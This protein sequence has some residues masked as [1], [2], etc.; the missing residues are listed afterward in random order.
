MVSPQPLA[1]SSPEYAIR[2]AG[3]SVGHRRSSSDF[4]I[5]NIVGQFDIGSMTAILG[6]NGAGKSTLIK[7]I[8]GFLKP[9]VGEVLINRGLRTQ[10]SLLPQLSDID[11]SFPI[12][13]YDLVAL[14]AWRRLGPFKAYDE[15]ER[16]RIHHALY[17]VGLHHQAHQLI[18]TLSGGQL[19]RALFARLIVR[20]PKVFLL[21][22]PFA[23][24]DEATCEDLVQIMQEWHQAGRTVIAVLHD[25][26]L[27]ARVFPQ[28]LLLAGEQIAW[29][30]TAEVLTEDNLQKARKVALKGF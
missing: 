25:A 21:D 12:S 18:G 23:A 7:T 16:Q 5:K 6:P 4:V 29:G 20:D 22:E 13:V 9:S 11:K 1:A 17:R 10:I 8:V 19:Q 2:L 30:A 3:V 24:I 27:V 14:G 15:Q 26:E 28:T